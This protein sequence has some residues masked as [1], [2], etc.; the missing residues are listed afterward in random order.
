MQPE[1]C[2]WLPSTGKPPVYV[3]FGSLVVDDPKG[4]TRMILSAAKRTHQRILLSRFA[5][6][7]KV[8]GSR[9]CRF[10][11]LLSGSAAL[12][13]HF[14]VPVPGFRL[15]LMLLHICSWSAPPAIAFICVVYEC[16][17]S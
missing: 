2:H 1:V 6:V 16:Q 12:S 8:H 9:F 4:L 11:L 14:R 15:P 17:G 13:L 3:G 5:C 10:L 7:L